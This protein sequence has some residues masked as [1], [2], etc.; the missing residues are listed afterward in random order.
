MK[1]SDCYNAEF[2]ITRW[3]R[4]DLWRPSMTVARA[5]EILAAASTKVTTDRPCRI[6][7]SL[8][9][10]QSFEILRKSVDGKPDDEILNSLVARNIARCFG[11]YA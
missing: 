2:R 11:R 6:N 8:N 4:S 5:R 7:R 10:Q 3:G 9:E 1:L